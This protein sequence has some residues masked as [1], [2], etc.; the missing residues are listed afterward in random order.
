MPWEKENK[1]V[2]RKELEKRLEQSGPG[3][4]ATED[5]W[6][7]VQ[8]PEEERVTLMPVP[9]NPA[10]R[11]LKAKIVR[12]KK[13][14]T[15]H[16]WYV[17]IKNPDIIVVTLTIWRSPCC[18]QAIG[19]PAGYLRCLGKKHFK[20]CETCGP[21]SVIARS[22]HCIRCAAREKFAKLREG[23]SGNGDNNGGNP[24]GGNPNGNRAAGGR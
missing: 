10:T 24:N 6:K 22:M 7:P 2:P 8:L 4:E 1:H 21:G 17:G 9:V 19:S 20:Q 3:F 12:S 11:R 16:Q 15:K 5:G 23:N 18:H 14:G 13:G